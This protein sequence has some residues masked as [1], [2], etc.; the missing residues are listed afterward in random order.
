MSVAADLVG[1]AIIVLTAATHIVHVHQE[2]QRGVA[3]QR[4]LETIGQELRRMPLLS[5]VRPRGRASLACT[6]RV[7][8]KC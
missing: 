4:H 1:V 5:T 8:T 7:P 2:E 6:Q 3:I